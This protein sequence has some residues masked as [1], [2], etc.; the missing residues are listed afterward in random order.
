[1]R[2]LVLFSVFFLCLSP[3]KSQQKPS[4]AEIAT[5]PEWAKEMYSASPNA[6]KV[7]S[8]IRTYY[9]QNPY[10]KSYHTQYYKRWRRGV[11]N[12]IN[13]QGEIE[14]PSQQQ[15]TALLQQYEAKQSG[16]RSAT[17][18]ALGP[19]FVS[20]P[21]FLQG[22]T[23]SNV[24]SLAISPSNPQIMYAGTEPGEIYRSSNAGNTWD[25]VSLDDFFGY[26]VTALAVH[27]TN[28]SIAYA[29][30]NLGVFKTT[31]AGTLWTNVLPE[32]QLGVNEIWVEPAQGLVVLAATEKGLYRSTD[33]GS[34]WVQLF[35][36]KSYDLAVNPS[37][38]SMVYLLKNDPGQSICSFFRST[39][40]G[41]TWSMQS[42]GWYTSTD[43]ARYDGGA[44]L[45]VSAADPNRV[46]AYLIGDSK[47]NDYGFIGVFK[48]TDAGQSWT[49]P[50][51]PAGGPYT[52]SHPNLAYGNPNWTYHQGFYNCALM[53]SQT[54]ADHLL[55]GG[56]NL[57]RSEDGGASF[58]SV[59]G[60]VGGP[61]DMHVD[62]Q[63][64]RVGNG[65]YWISTDGGIYRST[66]FFNSQ[67][68]FKM[69][70]LRGSDYWGFGSGWNEDVL[71]GGLYHNGNLAHH[72]NY[73]AGNFLSLGGAEDP[74]GYV[75]PGFNRKTYHSDVGGVVIPYAFG[76]PLSYFSVGMF[77]NQS[78]WAAESS[79]MEFHPNCY[80][81]AYIGKENSL[82]KTMDGGASYSLVHQFGNNTLDRIHYIEIAS[83]NPK[84]IYLNQQPNSGNLGKVWKSTDGGTTW[85][86]L[87]LP[88]GNSRRMLLSLNP[89]N[90]NEMWIAYPDGSNGNK[91]FKTSNGGTSWNN[92][93]S[94]VLNNESPQA[95]V[96][97]AGTD[98]AVYLFTQFSAYY[99]NNSSS[100]WIIDNTGLPTY[101]NGNIGRPFYR[102]GKIR[103]ASYGKGIWEKDLDE[104]SIL[105]IARITV[106][107][108]DQLVLCDPD[109]FYFEDYSFLNHQNAT[110]EWTFQNGQPA[111]STLR[112]PV[113]FFS[114]DGNHR[115]T[116]K[117]RDAQGNESRDTV[118][119]GVSR[120]SPST[121][122]SENFEGS[123][124]PPAWRVVDQN[125]SGQ[126]TKSPQAGSF[127]QSS[128][129]ALFAN[130]DI[131]SQGS[132]DDLQFI[133]STAN[134]IESNLTFDVAYAA[135]ASNYSDTLEVLIS[136]DCGQSFQ[137]L[138]KKGGADLSTAPFD[139][140]YFVPNANQWR[141]DT[142]SLQNYLQAYKL[143]IAFRNWG[144]WG[145]NLFIDKVN[146]TGQVNSN[147]NISSTATCALYPNPICS[148]QS[149]SLEIPGL[150]PNEKAQ[151]KLMNVQ[152]K[153]VYAWKSGQR[154]TVQLPMENWDSGFYM[155]NISTN[156]RIWNLPLLVGH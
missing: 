57:W 136:S 62:M 17:W 156:Q 140:S 150:N 76:D 78:Y 103:L 108:L 67:P 148:G 87:S 45:A 106:D 22:K 25:C 55:I 43:P 107:K 65:D 37:N 8:L 134:A 14:M 24:Y 27:P 86:T 115:V 138:Y 38:P 41:A 71:V 40:I 129:S 50:N 33:A 47:P 92:L 32:N 149:L 127:G 137:S 31:D 56:L 68:D 39:D 74:T 114:Q 128:N 111:T 88:P 120:L 152:G 13:P 90:E 48:S 20:N 104:P 147:P 72:E 46:Y 53:A 98:G 153:V 99:R 28:P 151:V 49:L 125:Q 154:E 9:S 100:G 109:S 10:E 52:A 75:N 19:F 66:D 118:F 60:Y 81:I 119:V 30:G 121:Q 16:N 35:T 5:L 79:E 143:M 83:S 131:D 145:N 82:W 126:W 110:W 44:R 54:N 94:A 155:V 113:V 122:I 132:A 70:G 112:N 144:Y 135:Y 11:S 64:F 117:I 77:P 133:F 1:M 58:S 15:W 2:N 63:D 96:H 85:A 142:V 7:D 4:Q 29:G 139:Q 69:Q 18:S 97:I 124:P 3:I 105:P 89:L 101:C 80:S 59:A 91:V 36:E 26:G 23:Q 141:T 61:L 12:F 51:G 6:F 93:S 84:V 116:L 21:Q 130:F 123:F 95:L 102:D 73:G 146:I 34:N 42:N